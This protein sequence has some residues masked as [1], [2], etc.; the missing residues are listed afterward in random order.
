MLI[1]LLI[2]HPTDISAESIEKIKS[3]QTFYGI[4]VFEEAV[5]L[6]GC[7]YHIIHARLKETSHL[8]DQSDDGYSMF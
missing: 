5:G 2:H 6:L 8:I 1:F 7:A 4:R 3:P